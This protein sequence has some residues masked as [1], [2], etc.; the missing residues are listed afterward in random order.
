MDW[1]CV[2][3]FWKGPLGGGTIENQWS[4]PTVVPLDS[5]ENA[6]KKLHAIRQK[7]KKS[8]QKYKNNKP[9]GAGAKRPPLWG[10][11]EGGTL[12]FLLF[13]IAFLVF[14]PAGM[15]FFLGRFHKNP[16]GTTGVVPLIFQ[17]YPFSGTLGDPLSFALSPAIFGAKKTW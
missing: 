17:W 3:G 15:L 8:N 10:A 14:L 7:N 4:H 5:Y 16:G 2:K 12:L 9:K 1:A 6:G 11:A 13:L